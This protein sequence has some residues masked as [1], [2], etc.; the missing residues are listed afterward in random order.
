M[1]AA[2]PDGPARRLL[3]GTVVAMLTTGVVGAALVGRSP[4][5]PARSTASAA[6]ATQASA[7]VQPTTATTSAPAVPAATGQPAAA[8][9]GPFWGVLLAS[10][11][12]T[13]AG[14]DAANVALTAARAADPHAAVIHTDAYSSLRRG[15]VAVVSD[16]LPSRAA[17]LSEAGRLRQ[18]GFP[19]A[20]ARC[21]T[22]GPACP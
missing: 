18:A 6:G 14:V 1:T 12:N 20:N 9:E 11:P 19:D 15:L 7:A 10:F 22:A 2:M 8:A 3:L 16:H 21:I 4:S 17:A 13:S 5:T